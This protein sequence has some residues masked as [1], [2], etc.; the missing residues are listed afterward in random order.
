MVIRQNQILLPVVNGW[1]ALET[2]TNHFQKSPPTLLNRRYNP[3]PSIIEHE[4]AKKKISSSTQAERKAIPG[5]NASEA[6]LHTAP[7]LFFSSDSGSSFGINTTSP[8]M[9]ILAGNLKEILPLS[10]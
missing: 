6:I 1:R 3:S 5:L 7:A 2:D 10:F 8:D 9:A 4:R